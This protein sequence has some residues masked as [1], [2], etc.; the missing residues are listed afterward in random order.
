M[1]SPD[2][3]AGRDSFEGRHRATIGYPFALGVY[4]VTFEEWDACVRSGGCGGHE[5]GDRGWGRGWRP[6]IS[7]SRHDAWAY[8]DWLT[9]RTGQEY[10][11]LSEAEWEYAARAGTETARFWGES[12]QQQCQYANGYDAVGQAARESDLMNPVGCRDRQA[13]PAPVGSYRPNAFGLF[14]V[15]G[16]VAEW[17]DDCGW[18]RYDEDTPVEGSLRYTRVLLPTCG[19]RR[20]L[21]PRTGL[22]T[23][24]VPHH[25]VPGRSPERRHHRAPSSPD[26]Q[27]N[28]GSLP[29]YKF[30]N[31]PRPGLTEV[32]SYAA[33][34]PFF[35]AFHLAHSPSTK[36]A[37][38]CT[39]T[40]STSMSRRSDPPKLDT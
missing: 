32:R 23:L 21:E 11:L 24:G 36:K 12:A 3:E 4:E 35:L 16:N 14:D 9:E 15:L 26:R 18:F 30:G 37:H 2:S 5:P 20:L 29:L 7:V 25:G 27:L 10:R 8:A 22:P 33:F 39:K 13:Y 17:V 31:H 6:A 28:R 1:G 34:F 19:A 38:R 40:A